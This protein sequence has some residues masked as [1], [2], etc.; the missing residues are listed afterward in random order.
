MTEL[1]AR[2]KGINLVLKWRLKD[3]E[4]RT[5]SANVLSRKDSVIT[6]KEGT[7]KGYCGNPYPMKVEDTE[8]FNRI[9]TEFTCYFCA[10]GEEQSR[11]AHPNKEKLDE[12]Q[13]GHNFRML[14]RVR[15]LE[16]VAVPASHCG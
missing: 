7:D 10:F 8:R 1:D 4:N 3:M 14:L 5:V 16:R 11:C 13:R 9:C 12:K 2:I 6:E 15:G